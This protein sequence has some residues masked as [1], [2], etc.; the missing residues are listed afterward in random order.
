MSDKEKAAGGGQAA[1]ENTEHHDNKKKKGKSRR[2]CVLALLPDG[3]EQWFCGQLGKA[4]NALVKAGSR[5][6]TA[7][8]VNS[9]AYRLA[10]YVFLL[11]KH[12]GLS[13]ST[14]QEPHAYGWHARYVL[15]SPV[16]ILREN[17]DGQSEG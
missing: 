6:I 9:W 13:I 10:A 8:E 4:I 17:D 3:N 5:G 15:N 14:L 1:S 12:F 11:R 7:L 2:R 16:I